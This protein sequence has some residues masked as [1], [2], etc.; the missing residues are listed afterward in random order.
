MQFHAKKM[1]CEKRARKVRSRQ[2]VIRNTNLRLGRLKGP[3]LR[4]NDPTGRFCY[5]HLFN[6]L[7]K[8]RLIAETG[9]DRGPTGWSCGRCRLTSGWRLFSDAKV[10]LPDMLHITL[11]YR[12]T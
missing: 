7:C 9:D 2:N 3:D 12:G 10:N 5:R 11:C 4:L 1:C 8:N 6:K